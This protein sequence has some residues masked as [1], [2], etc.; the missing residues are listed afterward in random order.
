MDQ[1]ELRTQ[2]KARIDQGLKDIEHLPS[3]P[4]IVTRL[5]SM[6]SNPEI[7]IKALADEINRDPAITA[8]IIRLSNSAYYKPSRPIRSVQEA[9]VTLGLN[10]VKNIVLV[11]ASRGILKVDL[12]SYRIDESEMWDHCLAV[13]EIAATIARVRK[14]KTGEDVAFTAGLL[15]DTGKVVLVHYFKDAYHQVA[16]ELEK[17]PK[18]NFLRLEEK[19]MGYNHAEIGARLLESW[20]FPPDLVEAVRMS[21]QPENAKINSELTCAVHVANAIALSAGV[22]IDVGGLN[23]ELSPFAVRALRL[24]EQDLAALYGRMPEMLE[25]LAD[26][27]SL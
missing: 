10:T 6:A 16:Q 7:D 26:L 23:Q 3:M 24:S 15:H 2:I 25:G 13:A 22:G 8:A 19:F 27:R 9:I 17:N 21:Y 11:A 4:G 20:E 18:S 14:L 12:E 1:A 5:I